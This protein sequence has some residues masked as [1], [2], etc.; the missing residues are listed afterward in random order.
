VPQIVE[1]YRVY[2]FPG[3]VAEAIVPQ[4]FAVKYRDHTWRLGVIA[5]IPAAVEL[6]VLR[7]AARL[8]AGSIY[9]YALRYAPQ[10]VEPRGGGANPGVVLSR[11]A[12]VEFRTTPTVLVGPGTL[13][14]LCGSPRLLQGTR[15]RRRRSGAARWTRG[16]DSPSPGAEVMGVALARGRFRQATTDCLAT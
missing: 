10:V 9:G 16:L 3:V 13:I 1:G 2:E 12:L 5:D 7:D 6:D 15:P 11:T 8:I 14:C 4:S